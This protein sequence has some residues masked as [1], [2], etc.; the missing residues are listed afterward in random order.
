MTVDLAPRVTELGG[1]VPAFG[2]RALRGSLLLSVLFAGGC[3]WFSWLPFVGGDDDAERKA[4]NKPA[5]L[6]RFDEE[7]RVKQVWSRSVGDGFGRKF[8][9]LN[10]VVIADRIYAGDGYG[11]IAAFDRFTGE[12]EWRTRIGEPD[13]GFFNVF[14]RR[15]P[16]FVTGGL[17][18]GGGYVYVGTALG[19]L[20]ALDAADGAERWRVTVGSEVLSEPIYGEG[21]VYVQTIDGR[22]LALDSESGEEVW[23]FDNQVPILTLRG[24][25]TPVYADGVVYAGFASGKVSALRAENGEP[26]WEHRVMLPEGRSEL[27]RMVDVDGRPVVLGPLLLAATYQGRIK[28]LRRDDGR[29][30]WEREASTFLDLSEGLGQVYVIN[31]DDEIKALDLQS[32]EDS[33]D[34][35]ALFR[36]KLSNPL[37]TDSYLVVGDDDGYL[38]VLAQSDG[39]FVGRRRVDG[40]GLRARPLLADDLIYVQGN[41]GK[42]VALSLENR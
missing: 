31:E 2:Y 16:S 25:A 4:S 18:G 42:L 29:P 5:E 27:D 15:D 34:Q 19:E 21:K 7:L 24:T 9:Y 20:I 33:W 11:L 41:G 32:A 12:R 3:S 39:R 17:G 36:R 23:R 1:R 10:P 8:L 30:L 40:K 22:L 37:A 26:I 14:D 35:D 38:H 13:G 28:A 6:E